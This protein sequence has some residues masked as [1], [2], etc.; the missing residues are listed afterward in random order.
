VNLATFPAVNKDALMNAS[1]YAGADGW[2]T[3]EML[4]EVDAAVE[5]EFVSK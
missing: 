5:S 1:E 3:A 4:E 2:T